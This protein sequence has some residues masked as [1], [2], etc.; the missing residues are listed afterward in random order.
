VEVSYAEVDPLIRGAGP[1]L[2]RL[3]GEPAGRFPLLLGGPGR[4]V[5]LLAPDRSVQGVA[6]EVVRAALS[7][8]VESRVAGDVERALRHALGFVLEEAPTLLV[9]AHP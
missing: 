3:P 9:I 8:E 6:P 7:R 1:A 4:R 2:L 5:S